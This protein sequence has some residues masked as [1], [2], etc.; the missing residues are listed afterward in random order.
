M[1]LGVT[2]PEKN[3]ILLTVDCLT[4]P[5]ESLFVDVTKEYCENV[6]NNIRGRMEDIIL[7]EM[8]SELRRISCNRRPLVQRARK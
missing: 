2:E 7:Q 8:A 1:T 6:K 4:L 5:Y 3:N